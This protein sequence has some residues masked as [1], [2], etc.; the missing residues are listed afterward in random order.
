MESRLFHLFDFQRLTGNS[1]L[2]R[3]IDEAG[4]QGGNGK[5]MNIS[6]SDEMMGLATAAGVPAGELKEAKKAQ[7]SKQIKE[8]V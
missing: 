3:L 5:Q 8:T 1:R 2:Q 6:L 7:E 4:E